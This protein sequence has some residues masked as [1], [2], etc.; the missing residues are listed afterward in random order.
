MRFFKGVSSLSHLCLYGNVDD[1][2]YDVTGL[3]GFC[4][5]P[6]SDE[7]SDDVSNE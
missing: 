7:S 1:L 6:E 5:A 3:V 2:L 4:L